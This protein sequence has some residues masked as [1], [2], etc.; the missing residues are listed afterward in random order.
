MT[1]VTP[2]SDYDRV[3][4]TNTGDW[5]AGF[6]HHDTGAYAPG[7]VLPTAYGRYQIGAERPYG[8]DLGRVVR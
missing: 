4:V 6:M 8:H 3:F 1:A 2:D 7:Q 5:Y